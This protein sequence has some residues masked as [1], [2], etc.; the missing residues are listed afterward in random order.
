MHE[1]L[2]RPGRGVEFTPPKQCGDLDACTV[3][4]CDPRTGNCRYDPIANCTTTTSTTLPQPDCGDVNASGTL[5]VSDAL[6]I[7]RSSVGN[8]SCDPCVC[9]VNANGSVSSADALMVMR[10]AVGQPIS[11]ICPDC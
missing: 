9:D 7:L 1:R 5:T 3:D 6:T 8:G 11:P 10:I 4:M 2:V